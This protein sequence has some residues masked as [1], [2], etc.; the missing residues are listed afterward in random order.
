MSAPLDYYQVLQVDRRADQKVIERVYKTLM[1]DLKA[2]PDLGGDEDRARLINL[3]YTT[4]RD[5]ERRR[6]YDVELAR[7]APAVE[8][9]LGARRAALFPLEDPGP[10]YQT[11]CPRCGAVQHVPHALPFDQRLQCAE[12][13]WFFR[14]PQRE[15]AALRARILRLGAA[16]RALA[17]R[18]YAT[19]AQHQLAAEEAASR[20]DEPAARRALL[21]RRSDIQ[22]LAEELRWVRL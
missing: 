2:H 4:L 6:L 14:D 18:L 21:Q 19:A 12:C 5:P 16:A 11:R 3:A 15:L 9:V 17:S 7:K 22:R 10:H 1:F 20:G 13:H 8:I